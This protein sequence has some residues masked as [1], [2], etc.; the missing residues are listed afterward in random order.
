LH[1]ANDYLN[2]IGKVG[3]GSVLA[4][5]ERQ[6]L[7]LRLREDAKDY[8]QSSLISLIDGLR[9]L[10][11]GFF[12]WGTVKFYYSVF[13]ALRS[14]LALSGE[15]IFYVDQKPRHISISVT[16]TASKLKGTTHKC[17]LDRFA[18]TSSLDF[19]LSQDIAN[20]PP[21]NWLVNKREEV[22]YKLAR[23]S[24]P[25]APS[26][27]AYAATTELRQMLSAYLSDDIYIHDPDH[28]IVAFP[29]RLVVDLR[30]RLLNSGITPLL[31]A[32]LDFIAEHMRDRAGII[33]AM[34]SLLF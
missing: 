31:Q 21:L 16:S 7:E 30:A 10:S 33:T 34:N 27:M 5:A 3:L 23:F 22:N 6:A 19:F 12:S 20:E 13:Y 4:P 29:F 18:T 24:E 26:Y 15:C 11:A 17:V 8:Y 2:S 28:A 1:A 9:S 25:V 14:R 32:E